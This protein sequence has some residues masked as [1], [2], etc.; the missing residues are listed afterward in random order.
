MFGSRRPR[1]PLLF[2]W[3][4]SRR[5]R[6]PLLFMWFWSLADAQAKKTI[7]FY[8]EKVMLGEN[9]LCFMWFVSKRWFATDLE[10]GEPF[11]GLEI[12]SRTP[13]FAVG[14]ILNRRSST[15]LTACALPFHLH[16]ATAFAGYCGVIASQETSMLKCGRCQRNGDAQVWPLPSSESVQ[17]H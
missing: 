13:C 7:T 4:G 12:S 3:F 9:T 14:G 2:M 8:M 10:V 15:S 11:I 5:P 16:T 6:K 17:L 1:K